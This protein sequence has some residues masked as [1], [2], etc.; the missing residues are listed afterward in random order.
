MLARIDYDFGTIARINLY[1]I[2]FEIGSIGC[3]VRQ[4]FEEMLQTII[5][6]KRARTAISKLSEYDRDDFE[7][8]LNAIRK[9]M[10]Q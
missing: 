8:R 2:Q 3:A 4:N 1:G 5:G 9:A 7:L 10:M 6:P